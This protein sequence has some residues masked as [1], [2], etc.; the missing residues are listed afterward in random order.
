MPEGQPRTVLLATLDA[1]RDEK[2]PLHAIVDVGVDGVHG[3]ELLPL[4][5]LDD[6]VEG[7][8]VN[9]GEGLEIPFR[10]AARDAARGAERRLPS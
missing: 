1:L 6:G 3:L 9:V 4:G 8:G 10:V 5:A 7:G 2:H